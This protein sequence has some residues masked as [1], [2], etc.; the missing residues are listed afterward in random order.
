[1]KCVKIIF[2]LLTAVLAI[3]LGSAVDANDECY[4]IGS[5]TNICEFASNIQ[6][7]LAPSLPMQLS[8][9]LFLQNIMSLGPLVQVGALLNYTEDY[10]HE[11]LANAG[12]P[13]AAVDAKMKEFTINYACSNEQISAFL[14]LGGKVSYVYK[15]VDGKQ[16]LTINL[17]EKS[18]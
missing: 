17:D 5:K 18:C 11:N 6:K 1:M 15:F 3:S 8:E 12:V 7:R 2:G 13:R 14:G 4:V 9:N 16:Y 10:L